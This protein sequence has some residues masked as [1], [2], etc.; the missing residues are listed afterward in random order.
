MPQH[1][2]QEVAIGVHAVDTGTGQ[3]VGEHA[4]GPTPRGR[5]RDDLGDH[6]IVEHRHDRA[7]DDAGVEADAAHLRSESGTAWHLETMHGSGLRLP[8]LG[9]ILRVQSGLDRISPRR[10]GIRVQV[11]SVGDRQ[12]QLDEVE[13]GGGLGDRVL[14]LQP[15]VH[16]Q[17][18]EVAPLV[19]HELDGARA[20]IP[21]RGRRQSRRVE[22]LGP[23]PR[24]AFDQWRRC[25]FDDLLVATLDGAFA[26]TDGPHGAVLVREY[27]DLDVVAGGEV[28]LA[29]HRRV[30]ERRLRL[31]PGRLDLRRQLRQFA[32]HPHAATA[33]ARRGLDQHR[34]LL[35][36][37]GV[38]I[39]FVEHRARPRRP[40]SSWP[41]SWS[42]SPPLRRSEGRSTSG[43][44]P[45]R[46]RRIRAFSERNP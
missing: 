8:A 1:V 16:L 3:R 7:V 42:P 35:R 5:V 43:R 2:H 25:L 29:E 40:S 14:D 20:G 44:R 15:G 22:Q 38:G 4:R 36:G 17:E 13:P 37:D 26:F 30:A 10:W 6:R 33:T 34:Q 12:L 19:G 46:R 21:D 18:E 28:A 32:H 31:A 41:R 24:R 9:R 27:L 39:E 11:V 45:A 23:H